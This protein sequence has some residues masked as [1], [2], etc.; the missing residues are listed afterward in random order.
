[1]VY[2]KKDDSVN[3]NYGDQVVIQSFI[4]E[5]PPPKNPLAFNYQRYCHFQNIHFQAFVKEGEWKLVEK[6]QANFFY[7]TA[8]DWQKNFKKI[9]QETIKN[10]VAFGI[11][12]AMLLGNREAIS[13]DIQ[14]LYAA[15]GVL[16]VLAV[17]GLHVGI[18][19]EITLWL[20]G[21]FRRKDAT[22]RRWQ[23]AIA[24]IVIWGFAF[25]VGNTASVTRAAIMF[26]FLTIGRLVRR[27]IHPL[28]SLAAAAFFITIFDPYALFQVGFQ[29]SFL[30]VAGIL[31]FYK[32]IYQFW[33]PDNRVLHFFWQ[34]LVVGIAAQIAVL[35]LSVYYFHQIPVYAWL[36]GLIAVPM[37]SVILY[38][39]L[40]LLAVNCFSVE[41]IVICL[42]LIFIT[43]RLRYLKEATLFIALFLLVQIHQ[44]WKQS[45]QIQ[46]VIYDLPKKSVVDMVEG[47]RVFSLQKDS[48]TQKEIDYNIANYRMAIGQENAEIIN[49]RILETNHLFING[50]FMQIGEKTV[51]IVDEKTTLDFRPKNRLACD[52]LLL[53][54][55]PEI[56]IKSLQEF[57]AFEQIIF[58]GSNKKSAISDWE[59]SCAEL[60]VD[61]HNTARMGAFVAVIR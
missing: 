27:D 19:S 29:F 30:A 50:D 16:H 31:V 1:L 39:S 8:Y 3:I 37:A 57:Y 26:S 58:D 7:Q 22:W 36:A 18:L 10:E 40:F 54:N 53:K 20:L 13:E 59:K 2:F 46:L 24:L 21:L 34:L 49:D 4:Q 44:N 33:I 43:K 28:N 25:L 55:S 60:D 52:Y 51:A 9:F 38:S 6:R 5:I 23:L 56:D 61:Y 41:G 17:S 45:E 32:S 47:Q 35:P 12:S 11:V 15:T 42:G 14:E 48:L